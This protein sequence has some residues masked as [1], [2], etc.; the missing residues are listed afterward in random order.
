MVSWGMLASCAPGTG[1][2]VTS[3]YS[4]LDGKPAWGTGGNG[5]HTPIRELEPGLQNGQRLCDK[6]RDPGSNS[7]SATEPDLSL[8]VGFLLC[9]MGTVAVSPFWGSGG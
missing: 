4:K 1:F 2:G 9:K 6:V 3:Y 5:N 8:S 7:S